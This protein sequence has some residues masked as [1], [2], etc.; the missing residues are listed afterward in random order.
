MLAIEDLRLVAPSETSS[1][2]LGGVASGFGFPKK[3]PNRNWD[4]GSLVSSPKDSCSI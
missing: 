4:C 1:G 2:V 3:A